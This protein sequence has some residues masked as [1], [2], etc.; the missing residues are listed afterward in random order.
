MPRPWSGASQLQQCVTEPGP[1]QLSRA[2]SPGRTF[3]VSAH[4]PCLVPISAA[5]F[6]ALMAEL[7]LE[8]R[9]AWGSQLPTRLESNEIFPESA[10]TAWTL[11]YLQT[12]QK[13][14]PQKTELQTLEG[15]RLGR[16]SFTHGQKSGRLKVLFVGK[17]R[18]PSLCST[19]AAFHGACHQ[20]PGLWHFCQT[21]RG[22]FKVMR[23][24]D[25]WGLGSQ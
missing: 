5:A 13:A 23:D 12:S 18:R 15:G 9:T 21:E 16:C 24:P 10:F 22:D 20:W 25:G 6:Q 3:L 2:G 17:L 14:N 1:T 11:G 8:T 4:F 7:W 19:K